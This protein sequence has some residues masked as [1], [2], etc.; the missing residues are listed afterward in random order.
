MG[1]VAPRYSDV[2]FIMVVD[3]PMLSAY[4]GMH[5]GD[6]DIA[7]F[8]AIVGVCGVNQPPIRVQLLANRRA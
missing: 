2:G 1:S 7:P 5:G 8:H 6:D 4:N 3:A